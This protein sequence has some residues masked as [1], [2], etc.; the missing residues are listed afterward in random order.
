MLAGDILKEASDRA[1]RWSRSGSCTATATSASAS[2]P[3]AG[4]TS[5]GSRPTRTACP[6]RSS[7]AT[8]AS[9]SP[10]PCRSATREVVA[11]IWRV[12]VGRVPLLLLD[13]DRPE[14]DLTD[15]W[16]TSRL[17]VGDAGHAAL[18][19]TRC[20]A[21]AACARCTRSA[22]S[23]GVVHLNEGH[24]AFACLELAR[25]EREAGGGSLDDAFEAVAPRAPS[26]PPTR[27][28]RRATTPTRPRRWPRRSA[29]SPASSASTPTTLVRR[30][31]THPDEEAEPFGVTQFALRSSRDRQRRQ[32]PPR[33]GRARDVARPVARPRRRGRPDH[34]RHQRRPHPDLDR[35]ARCA[36]CSTATSAR[37]GLDRADRPR[38]V[39][40]RRRHP[41]R[42]A[43]GRAHARSARELIDVVR[44]R[45]RDRPA[46]PRRHAPSTSAPPSSALDPDVLTIGFARRVATYKRLD[47]LLRDVDRALALLG[48]ER[49]AGP[50]APRRQ[51]APA[52]R[53]R[54]AARPAAVRDEVRT[55]RSAAA[56]ST[57]TTTTSRS[58]RAMVRGCD[59][60]VNVPRP[61]L[62]A[63]GTSGMKS[64]IN[65]GLQLSVLDG[66][67]PEAYDG[68]NGW[69]ISGEV[70]HDHGAQDWRHAHELYRLLEEEVVPTFY[71]RGARRPAA[72]LAARWSAPR[73]ARSGRSSAPARMLRDYARAD[74]PGRRGGSHVVVD[75][76]LKAIGH[77]RG[78]LSERWLDERPELLH[79]TGFPRRPRIAAGD[80]LVLYAS[81]WRRVFAICEVIGEPGAA[82]PPALAVDGRDRDAARRAGARRRPPVEAIGVAARSMSQ[83]SHIRILPDALRPRGRRDRVSCRAPGGRRRVSRDRSRTRGS[84]RTTRS[85]R[86]GA[87]C[88][89]PRTRRR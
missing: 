9:R 78:P 45:T 41:G 81:V 8:T 38:D 5:T 59:V 1:C 33:R 17:Y 43:V 70:D 53:R 6:P 25:A 14:N 19:S 11:Q 54:Q 83:Q 35:R 79:R 16:I 29:A 34:A 12:D 76:W 51:G 55:S 61:P 72:R 88:P 80:R 39:G 23:P 62:E 21:S 26:S 7:P 13:A 24:A 31:R 48:D 32:R 58:A 36:S 22:S 15:R 75:Y 57:S 63:R 27:R 60:W 74:L 44:E 73:C 30:G 42:G 66:W 64:A 2:T 82:R 20:S 87:R 40:R 71:D 65:G 10:S 47:L 77:A 85:R 67:W 84:R 86:R 28:S 52:R 50:A 3:P 4:S 68:T 46:R 49:P 69:A 89:S 56:S 18:A 37:A